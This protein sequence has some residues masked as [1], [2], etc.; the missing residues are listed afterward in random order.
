[1]RVDVERLKIEI[2]LSQ[3]VPPPQCDSSPRR[4]HAVDTGSEE[5]GTSRRLPA[6][7][8][9][10]DEPGASRAESR[11]TERE[12]I[13]PLQTSVDGFVRVNCTSVE[14]ECILFQPDAEVDDEDKTTTCTSAH[15]AARKEIPTLPIGRQQRGTA[16][17]EQSKQFDPRG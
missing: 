12:G 13:F 6:I 7:G 14:Q 3:P 4:S 17:T 15:A 9:G 11:S 10:S 8:T 5:P 2:L 1:M 16:S